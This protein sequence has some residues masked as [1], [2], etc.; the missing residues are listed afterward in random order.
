MEKLKDLADD[1]PLRIRVEALKGGI[2]NCTLSRAGVHTEVGGMFSDRIHCRVC[3]SLL[4][5]IDLINAV[6]FEFK[7]CL[8]NVK[9]VHGKWRRYLN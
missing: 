8:V 7:P 5:S 3:R 4:I 9:V 1:L 2:D 6:K